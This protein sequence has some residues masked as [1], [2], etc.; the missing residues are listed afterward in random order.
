MAT[1]YVFAVG[2]MIAS[3]PPMVHIDTRLAELLDWRRETGQELPLP[4]DLIV[5]L[6]DR[7]YVTD[8]E[9]GC[10]SRLEPLQNVI[11]EAAEAD[12][13]EDSAGLFDKSDPIEDAYLAGMGDQAAG[14]YN[15]PRGCTLAHDAY[16]RGHNDAWAKA[17]KVNWWRRK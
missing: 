4:A 14:C 10:T 2:K 5:W 8:L 12:E 3:Q 1:T 11:D 15:P 6:E 17:Q 13:Y 7:G 16:I 9:S